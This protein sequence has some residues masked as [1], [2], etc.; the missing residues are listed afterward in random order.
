MV[1]VVGAWRAPCAARG[2]HNGVEL[3][4]RRALGSRL[5]QRHGAHG[6]ATELLGDRTELDV[7]RGGGGDERAEDGHR[8]RHRLPNA[9]YG[10]PP[11]TGGC[12]LTMLSSSAPKELFL[13]LH[14]KLATSHLISRIE[15]PV[16]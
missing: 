9:T 8:G 15:C 12:F 13:D 7:V 14:T 10:R 5:G 4:G 3:G 1:V 2:R 11:D 16:P 6:G